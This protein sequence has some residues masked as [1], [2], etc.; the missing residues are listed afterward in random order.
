[1]VFFAA[2]AEKRICGLLLW[3]FL[4]QR[5]FFTNLTI[6]PLAVSIEFFGL[7]VFNIQADKDVFTI[8][9]AC[10]RERN[11]AFICIRV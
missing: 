8:L 7:E 2:N 4:Y 5:I 9:A 1:M 10:M 3:I 6:L 11:F